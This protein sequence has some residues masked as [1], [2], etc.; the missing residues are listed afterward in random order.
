MDL[1]LRE[2]AMKEE[3]FLRSETPYRWGCEEFQNPERNTAT[4]AQK[5]KQREFTT[6]I[7]A[8]QCFPA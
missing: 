7:S 3:M 2:R 5:A 1:H 6:E 8:N 4:G